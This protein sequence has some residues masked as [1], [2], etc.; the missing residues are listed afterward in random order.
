MDDRGAERRAALARR[1]EAAEQ[2][3][4]DREVD[5]GVVHHDHRVL[6]A[7]LEARRLEVAAAQLA[8]LRADRRGAREADLVDQ[9]LIQRQ[10]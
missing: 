10:L 9:P 1:A 6:A 3:A 7:E 2:R 5:V 4:L 8:D